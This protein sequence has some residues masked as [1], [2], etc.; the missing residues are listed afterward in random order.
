MYRK[1]R[2]AGKALW[3]AGVTPEELHPLFDAIGSDGLY[4]T[5]NMDSAQDFEAALKLVEAYR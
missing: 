3:L 2:D 4:L 5:V 1:I